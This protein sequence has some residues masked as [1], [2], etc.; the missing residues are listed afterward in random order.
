MHF[1]M[2]VFGSDFAPFWLRLGT[3]PGA[4]KCPNPLYCRQIWPFRN[5]QHKNDFGDLLGASWGGLGGPFWHKSR[6]KTAQDGIGRDLDY[7]FSASEPLLGR[8]RAPREPSRTPLGALLGLP[9]GARGP[10]RPK[11]APREAVWG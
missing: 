7:F 8:P 9:R 11:K 10:G 1:H 3:P 2:L 6:L 4:K 5:F